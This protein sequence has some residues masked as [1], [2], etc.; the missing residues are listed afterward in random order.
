[1]LVACEDRGGDKPRLALSVE[2]DQ[3]YGAGINCNM[4]YT[5]ITFI[6]DGS[7]GYIQDAKILVE[8]DE[9]KGTFVGTGSSEFVITDQDGIAEGQFLAKPHT[10]GVVALTARHSRFRDVKETATLYLYDIPEIEISAEQYEI[11]KDDSVDIVVQLTDQA[12][13]VDNKTILFTTTSGLLAFNQVTT[14]DNGRAHNIF[15]ANGQT[16]PAVIR[17]ALQFCPN[18]RREITIQRFE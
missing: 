18:E 11:H 12:D 7:K 3:L 16:G 15:E 13:N 4:N 5:N 10:F 17:A 2:N 1:M 9:L 8:Y 14:D 6:L